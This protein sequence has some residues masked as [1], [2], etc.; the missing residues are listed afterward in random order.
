[1]QKVK[2]LIPPLKTSCATSSIGNFRIG[3]KMFSAFRKNYAKSKGFDSPTHKHVSRRRITRFSPS[4]I[5]RA[6]VYLL[7]PGKYANFRVLFSA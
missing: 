6:V 7:K 4:Q 5:P 1:M 2:V 3:R